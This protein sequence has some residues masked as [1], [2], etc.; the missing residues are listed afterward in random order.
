MN[1]ASGLDDLFLGAA[2][3]YVGFE[4]HQSGRSSEQSPEDV[5]AAGSC[6]TTVY[7]KSPSELMGCSDG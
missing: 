7:P 5:L 2:R 4:M 3:L 1:S 6:T